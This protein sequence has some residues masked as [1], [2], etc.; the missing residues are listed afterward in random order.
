M[1]FA[2]F[3]KAPYLQNTSRWLLLF[4]NSCWLYTLQ[5]Y[6]VGNFQVISRE[7]KS[8]YLKDFTN[9]DFFSTDIFF[10][11]LWQICVYLAV[12]TK[13]MLYSDQQ[14]VL[15]ARRHLNTMLLTNFENLNS[16]SNIFKETH[17]FLVL[18]DPVIICIYLKTTDGLVRDQGNVCHPTSELLKCDLVQSLNTFRNPS[19]QIFAGGKVSVVFFLKEPSSNLE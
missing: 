6:I 18:T 8:I 10:H 7:K 2:I 13:R 5:L 16:I 3:L 14:T 1:N 11:F 9:L 4:Y 12:D 19:L 17:A 15:L